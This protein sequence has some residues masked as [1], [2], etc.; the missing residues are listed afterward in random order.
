M[1]GP[2]LE[3]RTVE[4]NKPEHIQAADVTR[5]TATVSFKRNVPVEERRVD[6]VMI[7]LRNRDRIHVYGV[8]EEVVARINYR[9][10]GEE[11]QITHVSQAPAF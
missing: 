11:V 1:R 7:A 6:C 3:F 10:R 9:L 5:V 4:E 8:L 2:L